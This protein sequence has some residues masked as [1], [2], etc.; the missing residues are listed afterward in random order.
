MIQLEEFQKQ[1]ASQN[2]LEKMFDEAMKLNRDGHTL[3]HEVDSI[4]ED[5]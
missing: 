2:D 5:F 3:F 4:I 1:G